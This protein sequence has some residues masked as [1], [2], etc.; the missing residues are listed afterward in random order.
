MS[1]PA[2]LAC[3]VAALCLGLPV[4]AAAVHV[5]ARHSA[6][7]AADAAALAAVDALTGWIDAEP[8]AMAEQVV[9]EMGVR[10]EECTVDRARAD[11]RVVTRAG[12]WLRTVRAEARAAAQTLPD[13][14]GRGTFGPVGVNGWAWPSDVRGVTQAFHDGYSI[15]LAV[16]AEGALFAPYRGVVVV[17]GP[18]G[19]GVP[20]QC[21]EQPWWWHGPNITVVMRH[22]TPDGVLFSSHNHVDPA[23]LSVL[24]IAPGIAVDA[25]QQVAVAGMSGCT[26]GPHSHFTLAS[27]QT[28]TEPDLNPY[29][30]LGLP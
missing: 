27:L 30:Y 28:N 12:E 14:S 4:I 25:G 8:C 1:A 7:V 10:L 20:S 3:S 2:V 23:S 5:E 13:S 18:D 9:L 6:A 29:L 26:S 17:A 22:E 21:R 19:G 16:S 11:A 24:G 15:D